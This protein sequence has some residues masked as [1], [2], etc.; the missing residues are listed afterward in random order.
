MFNPFRSRYTYDEAL[1]EMVNTY[2]ARTVQTPE[3]RPMHT[4]SNSFR[5]LYDDFNNASQGTSFDERTDAKRW[6]MRMVMAL[7]WVTLTEHAV[8]RVADGNP[9]PGAYGSDAVSKNLC[10]VVGFP[11]YCASLGNGTSSYKIQQGTHTILATIGFIRDYEIPMEDSAEGLIPASFSETPDKEAFAQRTML[12]MYA[13]HFSRLTNWLAQPAIDRDPAQRR[14]VE[15]CFFLTI[16]SFYFDFVMIGKTQGFWQK[17]KGLVSIKN[18]IY[19]R[20]EQLFQQVDNFYL[21]RNAQPLQYFKRLLLKNPDGDSEEDPYKPG[22]PYL[23][24]LRGFLSPEHIHSAQA[25]IVDKFLHPYTLNFSKNPSYS[26]EDVLFCLQSMTTWYYRY[27][28][29]MKNRLNDVIGMIPAATG[30]SV[31]GGALYIYAHYFAEKYPIPFD[32]YQV[33]MAVIAYV[34][35]G[36]A[37][38][39]QVAS[40]AV[41]QV[42][43]VAY[44][45]GPVNLLAGVGLVSLVKE[46]KKFL[47]AVVLAFKLPAVDKNAALPK[48]NDG[49]YREVANR[50]PYL[51]FDRRADGTIGAIW[52]VVPQPSKFAA[53]ARYWDTPTQ[54]GGMHAK[55]SIRSVQELQDVMKQG[56]SR[57]EL[58]EEEQIY[59]RDKLNPFLSRKDGQ[60]SGGNNALERIPAEHGGEGDDFAKVEVK[61]DVATLTWPKTRLETEA[62][63][64]V[65]DKGAWIVD[66]PDPSKDSITN[67]AQKG[68]VTFPPALPTVQ[69]ETLKA[70][71]P[72][73]TP[74]TNAPAYYV[75][76]TSRRNASRGRRSRSRT[77]KVRRKQRS[78]RSRSQSRKR[79]SNSRKSNRRKVSRS[80]S[81]GRRYRR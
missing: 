79:R 26:V 74:L 12:L 61:D 71:L 2:F 75:S 77:K 72:R 62:F 41:S 66:T 52:N 8:M 3:A 63:R 14:I 38:G 49:I 81:T 31:L 59:I 10:S 6:V 17:T 56:L 60:Q 73:T 54:T 67:V 15:A 34:P 11:A 23:T 24:S 37:L 5:K 43:S 51:E 68:V 22:N 9:N 18:E 44:Q 19:D 42:A 40:Q 1:A 35:Q 57:N 39:T 78:T 25:C 65:T 7:L 30:A 50:A 53:N 33:A 76:I 36:L 58:F 80:R 16:L 47:T 64:A 29:W 4:L 27:G 48:P 46:S 28:R 21:G 45:I 13:L 20:W 55:Q 32:P 70:L 69:A